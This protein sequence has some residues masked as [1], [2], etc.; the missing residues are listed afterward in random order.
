MNPLKWL[1]TKE[2]KE[3]TVTDTITTDTATAPVADT[4]TTTETPV[5]ESTP[6][7]EVKT[8]VKDFE[9]A[10]S[11]VE[12]GVA[13]LGAAAKDELKALAQKYL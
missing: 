10:F 6:V 1:L 8:G 7:A 4:V 9:A 11:F 12:Q 5:V 2:T 13:Q 3:P